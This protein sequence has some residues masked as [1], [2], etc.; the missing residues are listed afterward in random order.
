MIGAA[1]E[2]EDIVPPS[3]LVAFLFGQSTETLRRRLGPPP[4]NCL[5]VSFLIDARGEIVMARHH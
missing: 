1:G 4:G 3:P 5:Q 2:F